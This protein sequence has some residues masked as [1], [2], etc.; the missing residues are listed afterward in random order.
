ML[1]SGLRVSFTIVYSVII[2]LILLW[3][4]PHLFKMWHRQYLL[5]LETLVARLT[6]L[7]FALAV[8]PNGRGR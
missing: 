1:D 3:I 8:R 6:L 5:S 2:P 7:A 4:Y